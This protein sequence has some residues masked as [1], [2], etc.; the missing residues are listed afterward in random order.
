LHY[1]YILAR[2]HTP[3][4]LAAWE[5][6]GG[7]SLEPECKASLYNTKSTLYGIKICK[8]ST[9]KIND[10]FRNKLLIMASLNSN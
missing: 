3:L 7:G 4:D 6:E 1:V 5:A 8:L 10:V 9:S 2:R